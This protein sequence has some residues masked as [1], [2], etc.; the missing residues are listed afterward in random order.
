MDAFDP[1]DED[2]VMRVPVVP[3]V[4]DSVTAQLLLRKKELSRKRKHESLDTAQA[5]TTA[6]YEEEVSRRNPETR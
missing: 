4:N 2:T 5:K 3:F 6:S 1:A